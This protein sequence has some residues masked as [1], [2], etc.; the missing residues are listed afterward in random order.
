VAVFVLGEIR[1]PWRGPTNR[2]EFTVVLNRRQADD[3][4]EVA[5]TTN[6]ALGEPA[7]ITL[8]AH[9][10]ILRHRHMQTSGHA[11]DVVRCIRRFSIGSPRKHFRGRFAAG[12]VDLGGSDARRCQHRG[13]RVC[14]GSWWPTVGLGGAPRNVLRG[15]AGLYARGDRTSARADRL[16]RRAIR[17]GRPADLVPRSGWLLSRRSG[18]RDARSAS[19]SYRRVLGWLLFCSVTCGQCS[20]L[21]AERRLDGARSHDHTRFAP[22]RER[23]HLPPTAQHT[24]RSC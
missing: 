17:R 14:P 9:P 21:G 16:S 18:N 5:Q 20:A 6:Q 3:A 1:D 22:H 12:I 10:N 11:A 13:G 4:R 7:F 15:D 24:L 8:M 2:S 23:A 19:A